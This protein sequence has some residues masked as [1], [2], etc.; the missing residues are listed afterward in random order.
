VVAV[1]RG[2]LISRPDVIVVTKY[3]QNRYGME[4]LKWKAEQREGERLEGTVQAFFEHVSYVRRLGLPW[5]VR[6]RGLESEGFPDE[7]SAATRIAEVKTG[8]AAEN[9]NRIAAF[10]NC[11]LG[12]VI[13]NVLREGY[14]RCIFGETNWATLMDE[15]RVLV[16]D[17]EVVREILRA[18]PQQ[19]VETANGL[20]FRPT[21]KKDTGI[22]WV[23]W[24][25]QETRED[26]AKMAEAE[27]W[28]RGCMF[29]FLRALPWFDEYGFGEEE[30]REEEMEG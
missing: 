11:Y 5:T 30:F 21:K 9:P 10:S 1:T 19:V 7:M 26:G 27:T 20:N 28:L 17:W 12:G 3:L 6:W 23:P 29:E 24:R 8:D 18:L 25:D 16:R 22:A 15:G 4:R 13:P 2:F 14:L